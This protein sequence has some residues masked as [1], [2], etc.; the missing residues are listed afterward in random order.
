VKSG[1]HGFRSAAIAFVAASFLVAAAPAPAAPGDLD[2]GFSRDGLATNKA[3]PSAVDVVVQPD[4]KVV[5]LSR[6]YCGQFL[7]SRFNANGSVDRSFGKQGH[8]VTSFDGAVFPTALA[9]QANGRIV[10]V[11]SLASGR[12]GTSSHSRTESSS[13][14]L[15]TGSPA[16]AP[17]RLSQRT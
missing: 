9:V 3:A 2:P 5:T 13:S 6:C 8:A 7:V 14:V 4:G 15:M 10:A 1:A 11:G 12:P 16:R 17:R